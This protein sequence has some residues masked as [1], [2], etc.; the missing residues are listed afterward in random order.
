MAND[1]DN[2]SIVI[3]DSIRKGFFDYL[4]NS[5]K[6]LVFKNIL[7][8]WSERLPQIALAISPGKLDKLKAKINETFL[9]WIKLRLPSEVFKTL[10]ANNPNLI[11]LIFSELQSD[12]N[13]NLEAAT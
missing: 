1:C 8:A 4:D 5:A 9:A 13:E 3:E 7:D 11:A 10:V 12:D 2:E 6:V